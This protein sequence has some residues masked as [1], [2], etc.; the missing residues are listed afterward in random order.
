MWQMQEGLPDGCRD[1][2][3]FQEAKKR[4][5]LHPMHGMRKGLPEGGLVRE[6]KG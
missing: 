1:D 3:Q 4:D 2:G 5:G 6:K